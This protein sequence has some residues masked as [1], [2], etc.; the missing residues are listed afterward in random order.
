MKRGLWIGAALC[1]L[2]LANPAHADPRLVNH[3]YKSDEV[4]HIQGRLNV[5]ATIEFGDDEHIEN[6]AIGDSNAW[7]VTPNKRAN[8]LFIKPLEANAKTNMTVVTDQ[9]NYYFD[10]DA[11]G[12][13]TPLYVLAFSYPEKEKPAPQK[14]MPAAAPNPVEMAAANDPYAVVDPAVLNR[15][16][17]GAGDTKLLPVE[18]YDDGDA[19]FLTWPVGRP[20]PAI[21]IKNQEGIEGPVN[22]AVRDDVIVVDGVPREI[23]LRSGPN[24]ATLTNNGPV[25]ESSRD[26]KRSFAHAEDIQ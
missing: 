22:F 14:G 25:R 21:L 7:Q 8:L 5:Q 24:T 23:I 4:V 15:E 16:W 20:I 10:L 13:A 17:A 19:T 18:A 1:A 12:K 11:S 26:T 2:T 3:L 6:V 9:H